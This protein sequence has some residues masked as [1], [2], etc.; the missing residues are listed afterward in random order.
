ME[1]LGNAVTK[2]GECWRLGSNVST[3]FVQCRK[4]GEA[5]G[6][7]HGVVFN[8]PSWPTNMKYHEVVLD[9]TGVRT[10]SLVGA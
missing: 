7:E 8:C 6:V 4:C 10:G 2:G 9:S 3:A 5:W 1:R